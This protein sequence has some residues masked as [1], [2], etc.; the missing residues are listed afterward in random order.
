MKKITL[1]LS[2]IVL[3]LGSYVFANDAWF[4]I[5][6]YH[7][8]L[9]IQKDGSMQVT[10]NI[11]VNF[12]ISSRG[13]FR[14]IPLKDW[15]WDYVHITNIEVLW[16][17]VASLEITNGNYDVKIGD[18]NVFM[19]WPKQYTIRY[20]V[21]NAIKAFSETAS[22]STASWNVWVTSVR[23]EL[24]WNVIG[25]QRP[26]SIAQSTFTIRL[27]Q[28]NIFDTTS[29]FVIWWA[30]WEQN[31]QWAQI[32]QLDSSTVQGSINTVLQPW[33][34]ATIWLKFPSDYFVAKNDYNTMF[35]Q[36]PTLGFWN[37]IKA[38]FANIS[39]IV[40][41][42]ILRNIMILS[43]IFTKKQRWTLTGRHSAWH[44]NKAITP[45]YIPPKNIIP[46]EWFWFWYNDKNPQIF[47]ALLYYRANKWRVDIT[48]TEGKKYFF[49]GK[50]KDIF[51]ITEK[52]ENP[53]DA[54]ETDKKLLHEFF[55]T[56]DETLDAVKLNET[57]YWK[58]TRVLSDLG[59]SCDAS[60]QLYIREKWWFSK[61]YTLTPD[62]EKLFEEMRWYKAFLEKVE[63]PVIEKELQTDP[64]YL[65]HILPW[66]VLFGVET[67]LLKLCEDLLADVERYHSYNNSPLNAARFASMTGSIKSSVISP[68]SS[69]SL[70]SWFWWGSG[71]GGGL[72][73]LGG[74]I[75]WWGGWWGWGWRW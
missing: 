7:V 21:L 15:A 22:W 4:T 58:M 61:K 26:T 68:R 30:Q 35:S 75:S 40:R 41:I 5:E 6:Q 65:S 25:T 16:D 46:A 36:E 43:W 67:R 69:S 28:E 14:Q 19:T 63:R 60:K 34:W 24:Y 29:M 11:S 66:A 23:Q 64:Q 52:S 47:V 72:W 53:I 50:A 70:G 38:F 12:L 3:Y 42:I 45:Y 18:P 57:S 33:Q 71:F 49:G 20:K 62:G 8:D 74:G 13:I 17:P 56:P 39:I 31:S 48:L 37:T 9:D 10:E 27:P 44:S 54:T 51:I 55:G 32:Q 59:E 1:I 73:G 2:S